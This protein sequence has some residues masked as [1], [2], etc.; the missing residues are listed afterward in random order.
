MDL[1][2][3][4]ATHRSGSTLLQRLFNARKETLIWGENGGCLTDFCKI[5]DNT[6]RHAG[7][8]HRKA[9]F[10][11]GEDANQWIA[12]MTPPK[13]EVDAVMIQTVRNFHEELYMKN[14]NNKHDLI[15]YKEVRYGKKELELLRKCYPNCTII[16]L[17]RN[18]IDV[19]KSLPNMKGLIKTYG[20]LKGFTRVWNVR[21]NSYLELCGSDPNMHF[22]KYE[23]IVTQKTGTINFIKQV[24]HLEDK[25]INPVLSKKINSTSKPL[26]EDKIKFI[27]KQ[28]GPTMK[29]IGYLP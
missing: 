23:D 9:Y 29:K 18:P 3:S 24:G 2:I 15:G 26:P 27:M 20:S 10:N 17:V 22:V 5:L 28:C 8:K 4:S 13:H 1:V 19:W 11:N 21:V 6:R 12:C 25:D 7:F 16:L 14:Y